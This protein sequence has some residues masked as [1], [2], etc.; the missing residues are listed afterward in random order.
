MNV[1]ALDRR[2][3]PRPLIETPLRRFT[4]RI[5]ALIAYSDTTPTRFM[6]ALAAT[7]W[8]VLLLAPGDTMTRPVYRYM[9]DLAG[10]DAELKWA[11][12]WV[13]HATG[14]WWRTF[15]TVP[16]PR[17]AL[18]INSLGLGLFGGAAISIY[19]TLTYPIPAAVAPDVVL[20]LAALWVLAR[21]GI[22]GETGWRVD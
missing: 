12:L 2:N 21:T 10:S 13:L 6:L 7:A 5:W 9:A 4:C 20:A 11:A 18:A 16:R 17:I 19:A 15:S 1:S 22:N 14:M 8:A 3:N